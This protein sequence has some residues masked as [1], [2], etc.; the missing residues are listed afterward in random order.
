MH[1]RSIL[2]PTLLLASGILAAS[3]VL[4]EYETLLDARKNTEVVQKLSSTSIKRG[5]LEEYYLGRAYFALE[6]DEKAQKHLLASIRLDSSFLP[7]HDILAGSYFYSGNKAAAETEYLTCLRLDKRH[8]RSHH[9][10]GFIL[11]E[12]SHPK[13]AAEHFV[14]A[15]QLDSS[16]SD[17]LHRAG[18]SLYDLGRF[19][20]AA[21]WFHSEWKRDTQSYAATSL[22]M[23]SHYRAGRDDLGEAWKPRLVAIWKKSTDPTLR[24][25]GFFQFDEFAHKQ[26]RAI[27]TENFQ[28]EG[29]LYYHWSVHIQDPSGKRIKSV[30]LESSAALRE[31]GTPYI[32]GVDQYEATGKTHRTT[33]IGFGKLP[34]YREFKDL[35]RK[36]LDQ[37]LETSAKATY[38]R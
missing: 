21:S 2:G 11:Q 17:Y 10:L 35:V 30:N 16:R 27:A 9:M 5:Y 29:E 31:M 12:S 15:A 14:L 38:P 20:E 18:L 13:E 37:G 19:A 28:P 32:V 8:A 1:L 22:L 34:T 3:Q 6:D 36:E 26:L 25:L 24:Q 4:P 7:A 33:N 23:E